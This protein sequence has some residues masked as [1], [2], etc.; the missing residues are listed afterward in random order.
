MLTK[1]I[2]GLAPNTSFVIL[3]KSK[4][5]AEV[6]P[7]APQVTSKKRG[8]YSI[9]CWMHFFK[10]TIPCYGYKTWMLNAQTLRK[11]S[12]FHLTSVLGGKNSN[13]IHGRADVVRASSMTSAI[14]REVSKADMFVLF[15]MTRKYGNLVEY[16]KLNYEL[17]GGSCSNVL[18][19]VTVVLWTPPPT[20]SHRFPFSWFPIK[21][22]RNPAKT[23]VHM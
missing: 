12:V 17:Q 4:V 21:L 18:L 11:Q 3:T 2:L 9:K 13:E 5:S 23:A 14:L 15:L 6:D 16:P 20:Q 22:T 19:V 8:S 1:C 7:P 10:L